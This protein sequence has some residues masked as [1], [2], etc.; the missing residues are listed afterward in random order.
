MLLQCF[1]IR[2]YDPVG[3]KIYFDDWP[4]NTL[5]PIWLRSQISI[6]SQEPVLFGTT[7]YENIIYGC[8]NRPTE[9]QV[10]EAARMANA[11]NFIS[12]FPEGWF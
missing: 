5:D 1:I 4:I 6:V 10:H 2:Y 11:H 8:K 12:S 9:E 3:G 7:I